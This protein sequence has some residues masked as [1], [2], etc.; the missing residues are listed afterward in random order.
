ML[1]LLAQID[2]P[3]LCQD[4]PDDLRRLLTVFY[5][6]FGLGFVV[7]VVGH[8]VRSRMLQAAGIVMI[9]LVIA[10]IVWGASRKGPVEARVDPATLLARRDGFLAAALARIG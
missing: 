7:G 10:L 1:A 4:G 9:V 5:V 3:G 6:L 2:L 8:V